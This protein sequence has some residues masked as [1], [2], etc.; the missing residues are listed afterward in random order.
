VSDQVIRVPLV[1]STRHLGFTANYFKQG[2]QSVSP[3][4]AVEARYRSKKGDAKIFHQK[5]S[6]KKA[7]PND[8]ISWLLRTNKKPR[9]KLITE[10]NATKAFNEGSAVQKHDF[11]IE[12]EPGS[13]FLDTTAGRL[14]IKSI[15][16]HVAFTVRPAKQS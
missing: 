12:C 6:R 5:D 4:K 11:R 10:E 9:S 3:A 7:S 14:D 8:L 15:T 2:G 1:V 16:F 13:L